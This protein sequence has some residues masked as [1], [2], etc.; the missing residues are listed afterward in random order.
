MSVGDNLIDIYGRYSGYGI[1]LPNKTDNKLYQKFY[2][3]LMVVK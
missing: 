3:N 2:G 1:K